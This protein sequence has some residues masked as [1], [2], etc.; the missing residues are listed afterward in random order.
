MKIDELF[1]LNKEFRE[2]EYICGKK[3]SQNLIKNIEVIEIPE[4]V[5][6]AKE[7][8]L[9]VTTG[10]FIKSD[11]IV[12][13]NF[14]KMMIYYKAA[15]LLIKI[16]RFIERI[17]NKIIQI[18]ESNDFPIISIPI[19]MRYSSILWPVANKLIN[20][21]RY[22]KY[23]LK[24]YKLE[25]KE[26]MKNNYNIEV[27]TD[28]LSIYIGN[29]VGVFWETSKKQINTSE[30][31]IIKNMG[32]VL[33]E[34]I[35]NVFKPEEKSG[36]VSKPEGE[37]LFFKV[38]A[39]NQLIANLCVFTKDK[40]NLT[41]TDLEI[42]GETIPFISIYLL[43]NSYKNLSH[44]KSLEEFYTRLIEGDY[45]DN[46]MKAKEEAS[47]FDIDYYK[48]R[49][50]WIIQF[51]AIDKKD[52][53]RLVKLIKSFLDINEKDYYIIEK[54]KRIIIITS[55][56][57]EHLNDGLVVEFYSELLKCIDY[58]Y[59]NLDYYIGISKICNSLKYINYAHEE[60]DFANKLGY[61]VHPNKKVYFYDD[62]IVYHLLYEV[63]NHPTLSKI[64]RN[65]VERIIKYDGDHNTEL[66]STINS[67]I[68]NDFNINK[69]SDILFIH[70]NTLYKRMNKINNLLDFNMEKSESRLILQLAVKLKE[71]LN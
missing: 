43:S 35:N 14:L 9:L 34:N 3:G 71:I 31:L 61:K 10:Y 55:T 50:I 51:A 63:S 25:L 8:D 66:Y 15:G 13:E 57:A 52:Y 40:Q 46:E 60:A 30:N 38:E 21:D 65:T 20:N 70:R 19:H 24:K 68:N 58:S 37:Y 48:N 27:I 16:G 67:L 39:V 26:V 1:Q 6:W 33:V 44:Y 32:K 11:E 22:D 56:N 64:Y 28:L 2:F 49:Y 41:E 45:K 29:T 12:F 18:A 4:G 54:R 47:Y 69:T 7:G 17:P 42:I 62:Y 59:K 53:V 5:N 36:I 23:I